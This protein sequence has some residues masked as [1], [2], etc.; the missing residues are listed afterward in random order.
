LFEGEEAKIKIHKDMIFAMQIIFFCAVPYR[1]RARSIVMVFVGG[2][3]KQICEN[4][5]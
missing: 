5:R 1:E 3:S 2:M 4:F